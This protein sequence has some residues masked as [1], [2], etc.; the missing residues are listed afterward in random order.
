MSGL[1]VGESYEFQWW[2]NGSSSLVDTVTRATAGNSVD[3]DSKDPNATGGIGQFSI[4]TFIAD[5]AAQQVVFSTV[6][7]NTLVNGFQLR[8]LSQPNGTPVPE[9]GSAL[10][11]AMVLGLCGL[12]GARR[13]RAAAMTND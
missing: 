5:N 10:V 11:G 1:V 13:R 7:S 6:L 2:S 3:L 4:G 9:P 12:G 8:Q